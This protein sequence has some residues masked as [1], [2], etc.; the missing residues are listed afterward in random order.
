[1]TLITTP[2]TAPLGGLGA[3]LGWLVGSVLCIR[4]AHVAAAMRRAGVDPSLAAAFYRSLGRSLVEVLWIAIGGRRTARIEPASLDRFRAALSKGRG[5]V[6]AASHTGNFELAA[7]H[8]ASIC[9]LLVIA[10][11]Q[12]VRLA[13]FLLR[14]GADVNARDKKGGTPLDVAVD[15]GRKSVITFIREQGGRRGKDLK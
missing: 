12:S 10:K 11:P 9:S 4:R 14:K 1:M 3:L 15:K 2:R 6:I 7:W 5:V 8:A 13:D